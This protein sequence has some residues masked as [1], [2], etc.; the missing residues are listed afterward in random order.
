MMNK[1]FNKKIAKLYIVLLC[2]T[3]VAGIV[4]SGFCIYYSSQYDE[5]IKS[6][7]KTDTS[8]MLGTVVSALAGDEEA[9]DSLAGILSSVLSSLAGV[10]T[11]EESEIKLTDE[12]QKVYNKKI[13]TLVAL[14]IFYVLAAAFFTATIIS[15]EYEKYLK[16]DKYKAKLKRLKKYEK[17][18]AK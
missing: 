2:I 18:K 6:K 11:E 14:I 5:I 15:F 17:M 16:S 8:D 4:S 12:E 9:S 1:F 3:L 13:A 10:E 7:S